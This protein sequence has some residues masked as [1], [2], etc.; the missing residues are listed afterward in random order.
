MKNQYYLLSF[1]YSMSI[2]LVTLNAQTELMGKVVDQQSGEPLVGALVSL[3]E[4][5][6]VLTDSEGAFHLTP[7]PQDSVFKI[8]FLGYLTY[9][10]PVSEISPGNLYQLKVKPTSLDEIIVRASSKT[11]KTDFIGSNYRINPTLLKNANP[12]N[13]EEI[14]KTIPGVNIVGD[15]GLSNRPNISIRGSWGRR[16]KKV[17]LLEDGSPAA[18]APYIAPGAYY[19]PVSDRIKSIEVYKGADML[20]LG[21]NNMY[22]AIN[23]ITALPSIEPELRVK[24]IGGQRNYRTGLF[25]YGGS[26]ENLG[27]L[28][29]IVNKHFDGFTENS[30]VNILN[31]NAKIF[32]QLS[33]NQSLYFKIS[34]QYEKNQASLSALTPFSFEHDPRRNP[35]DADKFTMRRYGFDLI[36]K[37]LVNSK[38]NLTSKIY[39]TDFERDW[40]RQVNTI[41]HAGAVQSY[42]GE[43]IFNQK[44]K[45]LEG[46][47]FGPND[48]VRVGRILNGT[49]STT[50]SRWTFTVSGLEETLHWKHH[51]FNVES[52]FEAGVKIHHETYKDQFLVADNSRWARSGQ[53]TKD[54]QYRL[55]SASG[56]LRNEFKV[57]HFR[58]IP[59]L[60]FEHIHMYRQ[61]LLELSRDPSLYGI[62]DG[63]FHNNY[64]T[65]LPGI[66]LTYGRDQFELF[67]SLYQGFIAP[68][69]VFGFYVE[70]NGQLVN[71]LEGEDVN[72]TPEL[73]VNTELGYR[74]NSGGRLQFEITYFGK[75]VRNFIAAGENEIFIEPG[76]VRIDGL[77]TALSIR[78]FSGQKSRMNLHLNGTLLKSKIIGG[79][80]VDKDAFG[81]VVHSDLTRKEFIENV[82]SNRVAYKIFQKDGSGQEILFERSELQESDFNQISKVV[83]YFGDGLIENHV[84][85]YSPENIM[86]ATLHYEIGHWAGGINFSHIGAQ[87]AEFL[88]FEKESADGALGRLQAYQTW[89]AYI[90]YN[91]SVKR[92]FRMEIF[93][94]GKNLGN[95]VYRASRLNRAASG[96]FPGGFRQL[97]LGCNIQ[98]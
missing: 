13:T 11:Y 22:G 20:R 25:S 4:R 12:L 34:G 44:Y 95:E 81:T 51:L 35:F 86:N 84:A 66:T 75:D 23:Y 74:W 38:L 70:R 27:A 57:S 48:Y 94:N 79:A 30:S 83:A 73:S 97:I 68:S 7:M 88:N 50:D 69:K 89:D 72:I 64:T 47:T 39:A 2:W 61:D 96:I 45:Y 76:Q 8:S 93:I 77:E 43:E 55:L 56:F 53:T 67:G 98:V 29:E 3:D 78:L 58:L 41:I 18:P 24:L 91:L 85:P 82:N 28:I 31:L 59:I 65:I 60:H 37:W 62:E 52:A 17:L 33:E 14:L 10:A 54:Q 26:W 42:V 63:R 49:E 71:P 46:L 15:M 5:Q 32:S 40:W 90:N 1:L 9:A 21:P 87:Y 16:S 6:G 80:L 92:C 19:N 36:H